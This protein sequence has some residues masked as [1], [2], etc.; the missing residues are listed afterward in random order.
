MVLMVRKVLHL[1][2]HVVF[3]ADNSRV[4]RS[5]CP[6]VEGRIGDKILKLTRISPVGKIDVKSFPVV[7]VCNWWITM[8]PAQ[9]AKSQASGKDISS[10][11]VRLN[12]SLA[13]LK[14]I[15]IDA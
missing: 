3:G 4:M 13:K 11:E 9:L 12:D 10:I 5:R 8:V 6:S 14:D 7:L 15:E 2:F 1:A